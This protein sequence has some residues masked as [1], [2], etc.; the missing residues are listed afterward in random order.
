MMHIVA[1]PLAAVPTPPAAI[2]LTS[3]HAAHALA[4]LPTLWRDLPVYCVGASTAN[5][6][7]EH[8]C[9]HIIPGTSDVM[10]LLPR[11]ADDLG[12]NSQLLYLAGE[13]TSVD[14]AHLLAGRNVHVTHRITYRA[15]AE[16]HMSDAAREALTNGSITGVA[17]FSPRS[18]HITCALLQ[19]EN[20]ADMA[21]SL[22]VPWRGQEP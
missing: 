6:A 21:G 12:E 9:W 13:D 15:V 5:A 1:H 22:D 17:F 4:S 20:L 14:V 7:M 2:L 11:I 3:R 16:H 19:A 8:K 10:T 18:A